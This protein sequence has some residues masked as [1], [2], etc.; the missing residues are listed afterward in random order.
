M[1]TPNF[2][3]DPVLERAAGLSLNLSELALAIL[4]DAIPIGEQLASEHLTKLLARDDYRLYAYHERGCV[5][6]SALIYV[7]ADENFV[8][9]DYMAVHKDARGKG[10]GSKLFR[11]L[12]DVARR[13]RPAADWVLLEV[14][15]DRV[16]SG[17]VADTN[18][19]RIA[20]YR[21]LGCYLLANVPYQFPSTRGA[22]VP[23][24]L[25]GCPLRPGAK[26]SPSL[27]QGALRKVFGVIHNRE[28]NDALL[29]WILDRLPPVLNLG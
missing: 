26:L 13:E 5:V 14:D 16:A 4:T 28:A 27:L 11:A 29:R 1:N 2:G 9:L 24:R 10:I 25:M 12:T 7:P 18:R 22:P 8:W 19:R 6:A 20:F 15:D 21:R 17:P 23:M 3:H